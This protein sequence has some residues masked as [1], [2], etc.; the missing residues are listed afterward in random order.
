MSEPLRRKL[1]E[2]A[3]PLEAINRESVRETQLDRWQPP[4]ILGPFGGGGSIPLEA[5]RLGLEALTS[6][7]T[8]LRC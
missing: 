8:R 3:L 7:S 6:D 5:Q 4:P 1:I 2:V